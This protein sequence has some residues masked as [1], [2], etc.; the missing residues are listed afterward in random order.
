MK[1]ERGLHLPE[2]RA[3]AKGAC[4]AVLQHYGQ[5]RGLYQYHRPETLRHVVLVPDVRVRSQA[6]ESPLML[7]EDEVGGQQGSIFFLVN[8]MGCKRL[9]LPRQRAGVAR[10]SVCAR[11]CLKHLPCL[12]VRG[13]LVQRFSPQTSDWLVC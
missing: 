13:S 4:R 3:R 7:H 2:G 12:K 10:L 9:D 1:R 8:S 11:P 6:T 5:V